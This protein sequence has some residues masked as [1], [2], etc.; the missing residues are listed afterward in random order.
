MQVIMTKNNHIHNHKTHEPIDVVIAWVDGSDPK[1]AEKRRQF[2][3]QSSFRVIPQ[4]AQATRF[5]SDNEIRYCVLS[6][7][8]FAPFV[9]NIFI[10]TDDQDPQ[11]HEDVRKY[12]PDRLDSIRIVDHKEIFRDFEEYLPTF[13]SI[14]IGNMV[15]RIEGL[16]ENFVY[17][18]DDVFLIREVKPEDWVIDKRPVLRGR[19]MVPPYMKLFKNFVKKG[20]QKYLLKNTAYQPKFSFYLVQ[21]NA[22]KAAGM[23]FRFLFNCHTPHVINRKR[24]ESFYSM[25][26][27]LLEKNISYRFRDLSQFNVTTLANHLEVLDGN[28]NIEKLNLGYLVPSYYSRRKLNRKIR[29]C[30][31]NER[32]KSV[33]VQSLDTATK[34]DQDRIFKWM[35]QFLNFDLSS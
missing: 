34:E 9:R 5:A 21:W 31:Q 26:R 3:S 2:L 24:I 6:I 1:L 25:N 28:R 4:G 17:F 20:I 27:E 35:D 11:V 13:N 30:E 14:S 8:K 18:N 15:W 10:V 7:L 33:C 23:K 19:F 16:S 29:R 12:F 22:A 32:V